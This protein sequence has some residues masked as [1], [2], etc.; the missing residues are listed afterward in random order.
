MGHPWHAVPP[1]EV[2]RH[3]R[4]YCRSEVMCEF[5]AYACVP[6]VIFRE[7]ETVD[8]SELHICLKMYRFGKE[9]TG[10]PFALLFA[11]QMLAVTKDGFT[12][13]QSDY[14]NWLAE[15]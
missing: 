13:H 5:Q 14:R 6:K 7:M 9:A 4:D 15:A 8:C 1:L 11:S 3:A 2:R 12:Y 10:H